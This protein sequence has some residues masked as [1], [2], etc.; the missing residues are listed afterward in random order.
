[1]RAKILLFFENTILIATLFRYW[2]GFC[3]D[4]RFCVSTGCS[5]DETRSEDD[6]KGH[7]PAYTPKRF[8][9]MLDMALGFS[10]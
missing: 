5:D 2:Y 1:M 9:G 10:F 8:F 6:Y 4:A 3:R 7:Y